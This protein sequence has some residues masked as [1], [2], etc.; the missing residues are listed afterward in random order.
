MT[1]H[2]RDAYY[3]HLLNCFPEFGPVRLNKL[4][5]YFP[6]FATAFGASASELFDAT[7]EPHIID[8]WFSAKTKLNLEQSI[9]TLHSNGIKLL[10]YSDELYPKMLLETA[11]PPPILYY[12]GK[13]ES[14]EELCVGVVGTRKI[15]AYGQAVTPQIVTPLSEA[16][17]TIVSGM[18]YGVDALAHLSATKAGGRTIAV[19]G[20]GLDNARIYPR[21]HVQLAHDI[22][23]KGGLLLS[24][25]PPG[26]PSLRQHFVVRNRIIAGLSAGVLIVECDLKSGALITA[27]CARD[28]NRTVYAVPGSIHAIN[29]LGPN[30]LLKDGAKPVTEGLD[31]IQDL[32]LKITL[33]E[34]PQGFA[35]LTPQEQIVLSIISRDPLLA[36]DIIAGLDLDPSVTTASLT[37][38]EMKGYIK[39]LGAQQYVRLK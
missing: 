26:R 19:L 27:K 12:R 3:L 16:G 6:D 23:D 1:I 24:E 32:N 2:F 36:D 37:F 35:S 22:L 17:I 4:A 15:S 13:L 7:I 10:T 30:N 38:L 31:I 8:L 28:E 29:S 25:Y 9:K 33:K 18:A 11:T 20:G 21:H 5:N 39:N 14:N 34:A